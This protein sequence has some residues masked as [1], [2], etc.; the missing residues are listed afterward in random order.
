MQSKP[1]AQTEQPRRRRWLLLACLSVGVAACG[2][3]G[4]LR[5][6]EATDDKDSDNGNSY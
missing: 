1:V 5:L 6:P 3:R 4:D 2:R